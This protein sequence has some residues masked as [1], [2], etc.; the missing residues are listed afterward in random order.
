MRK[1]LNLRISFMLIWSFFV[2]F[3]FSLSNQAWIRKYLTKH[4]L[5]SSLMVASEAN[6]AYS[7]GNT[8]VFL[9]F[10][11]RKKH[12]GLKISLKANDIV[13]MLFKKLKWVQRSAFGDRYSRVDLY[14][15]FFLLNCK[16]IWFIDVF[17]DSLELIINWVL[18]SLI[19]HLIFFKILNRS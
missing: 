17:Y 11:I 12:S 16:L 2:Q 10:K 6:M 1:S 8:A 15:L 19:L 4:K 14:L 9:T 13:S 18:G 7:I 3:E 5:F